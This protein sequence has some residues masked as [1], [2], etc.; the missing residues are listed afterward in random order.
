M[1]L[2]LD[3]GIVAASLVVD[4]LV[5]MAG[6]AAFLP[7]GLAASF[8]SGGLPGADPSAAVAPLP[9]MRKLWQRGL[10][11]AR[12]L[13]ASAMFWIQHPASLG[14]A[15]LFTLLHMLMTFLAVRI[16][17]D[18]MGESLSF[19]WI[20]G[21]WS[22]SY[23]ISLAPVSINGL[24]LQEVSITYLYSHFGGVSMNAG[25][26][27]ALFMRML[28]MLASL[29]GVLFLPDILRPIPRSLPPVSGGDGS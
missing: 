29:P 7:F 23:F 22:F 3:A 11:F 5:G 10:R 4:R 9:L 14:R 13:A 21:L 20:G 18:G 27:L 6:M 15:F 1:Y 24:G 25:L 17:L 19:W 12:S 8:Q 28:P 26:V 2:R 16:L